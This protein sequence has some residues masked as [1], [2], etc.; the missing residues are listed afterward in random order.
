MKE[1]IKQL[2]GTRSNFVFL[3]EAGSGKS[4]IAINFAGYLARLEEKPVHFFDLDMTKPLFRSRD[5][6]A[7]VEELGVIFHHEEQFYDAP[8]M[9][10]GVNLLLKDEDSYV[11]LD[12]GGSD[13]GARAFGGYAPK[14][15]KDNTIVY[16]V[17]NAFRPWSGDIEHIDGTLSGIL[18]V[19]HVRLGQIHMINNPNNGITTTKEEVLEGMDKMKELV[20]PYMEL[21]FACVKEDLYADVK[22]EGVEKLLPIKLYLT[23]E[24]LQPGISAAPRPCRG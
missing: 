11:I 6:I 13:I 1:L 5:V 10:G 9:V 12:V 24:W 15:N 4:E 8:T 19:S 16:Y 7:Q 23:Y 2:I 14:V 3:G 21:D 18:G 17:L 20:S 22:A